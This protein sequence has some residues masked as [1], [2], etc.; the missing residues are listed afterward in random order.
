MHIV[1]SIATLRCFEHVDAYMSI[2]T[3]DDKHCIN[4]HYGC[5]YDIVDQFFVEIDAEHRKLQLVDNFV[6]NLWIT[7]WI[8]LSSRY[9]QL[10]G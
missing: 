3:R 1:I 9:V 8:T 2:V 4:V 5:L 7:L 10:C 6:D